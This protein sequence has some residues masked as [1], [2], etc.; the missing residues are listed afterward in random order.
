[1]VTKGGRTNLVNVETFLRI[2]Y[3]EF[4]KCLNL[5]TFLRIWDLLSHSLYR[6]HPQIRVVLMGRG[7][8]GSVRKC[9]CGGGRVP[10][11]PLPST[12]QIIIIAK[13]CEQ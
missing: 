2:F 8:S 4:G 11:P 3:T 12:V 13:L 10:P 9:V 6:L 1:M 5:E 7:K